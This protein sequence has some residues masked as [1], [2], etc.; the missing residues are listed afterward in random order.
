MLGRRA[1]PTPGA[2]TLRDQRER[3]RSQS[4]SAGRPECSR[5]FTSTSGII[6]SP[7][8]P[9]KY[10]N[11]LDCTFMIF[12]PKMS[13]I[14]L[15]FESFELEPDTTPPT[16]VFCRYDR[17]EIWDGFPGGERSEGSAEVKRVPDRRVIKTA[18]YLQCH[19]DQYCIST[20]GWSASVTGGAVVLPGRR[21]G[22]LLP[23]PSPRADSLGR[24]RGAPPSQD[25][26]RL[27]DR[28]NDAAFSAK[29]L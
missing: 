12:A 26:I 5:N 19:S 20:E 1:G 3:A 17:L 8:F 22:P 9:E 21:V 25:S 10:P 28:R 4:W 7:G 16:G 15:E 11:N 27:K 13:E 23:A 2:H 14:V 24:E 18:H 29:A 6:K